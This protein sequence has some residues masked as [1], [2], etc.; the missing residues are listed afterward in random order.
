MHITYHAAERFLQRV[1]RFTIYSKTQI[2]NAMQL[3]DRDLSKLQTRNKR[4][5]ILPSFPN[6]YGVFLENTL[7][8]VIPKRTNA[9]L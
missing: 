9:T 6:F 5:V 3:L 1:F 2:R 7:V 8:T 4:H